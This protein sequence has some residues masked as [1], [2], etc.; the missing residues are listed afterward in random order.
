MLD[1]PSLS[2][3]TL[4][5]ESSPLYALAIILSIANEQESGNNELVDLPC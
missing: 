3:V 5:A 2:D 1:D 4:E